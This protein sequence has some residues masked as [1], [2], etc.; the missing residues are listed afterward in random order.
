ML[1]KRLKW[2]N[3]LRDRYKYSGSKT[4]SPKQKQRFLLSKEKL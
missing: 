3:S 1:G 4:R 2:G